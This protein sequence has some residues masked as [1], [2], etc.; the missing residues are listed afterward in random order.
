M[1]KKKTS[2]KNNMVYVLHAAILLVGIA[3]AIF[4]FSP[5]MNPPQC[6][7]E[8]HSGCIVGANI[9]AGLVLLPAIL[10]IVGSLLA[11]LITYTFSNTKHTTKYKIIV[12]SG[13]TVAGLIMLAMGLFYFAPEFSSDN[14]DSGSD[15]ITIEQN[16]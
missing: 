5:T 3:L 14:W 11:A 13:W 10:L 8:V 16:P 12:V 1:A 9:G 4:A 7:G 2:P 6:E 15:N